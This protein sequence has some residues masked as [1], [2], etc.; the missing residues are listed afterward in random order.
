MRPSSKNPAIDKWLSDITGVD[1]VTTIRK[2]RCVSCKTSVNNVENDF[3]D[4]LSL[5]EY[6]ISGL[7]QT[8][9]DKIYPDFQ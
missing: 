3:R 4:A 9:Q 6:S 1:R 7:C 8:C 2:D 5:R